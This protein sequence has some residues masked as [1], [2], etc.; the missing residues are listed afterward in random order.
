M[1]AC[2][3]CCATSSQAPLTRIPLPTQTPLCCSTACTTAKYTKQHLLPHL[4]MCRMAC[5]PLP[6]AWRLPCDGKAVAVGAVLAQL[7]HHRDAPTLAHHAFR[8]GAESGWE[9]RARAENKNRVSP[10]IMMCFKTAVAPGCWVLLNVRVKHG[11]HMSCCSRATATVG[12]KSCLLNGKA[13]RKSP[14]HSRA[15]FAD[16]RQGLQPTMLRQ[17]GQPGAHHWHVCCSFWRNIVVDITRPY[18]T[19]PNVYT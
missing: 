10:L 4:H 15:D 8:V 11:R 2:G 7:K 17:H 6:Q 5:V 12:R 13:C 3:I 19:A 18:I 16:N 9:Q 1:H 14:V